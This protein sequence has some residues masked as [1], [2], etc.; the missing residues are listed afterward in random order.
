[1]TVDDFELLSAC[2]EG[3]TRQLEMLGPLAEALGVQEDKVFYLW[4]IERQ[5]CRQRGQIGSGPWWY[6]F[7]GYGCDLRNDADGR[8]LRYD[9]GPGGRADCLSSWGVLQ[10]IMTTK[11]PWQ[12]F[13][14]LR[15][16]MAEKGP[17]YDEFSGDLFKMSVA[18]DR[19]E[20]LGCFEAAD[21][22]LAEFERRCTSRGPD[23]LNYVR[24]PDGTSDQMMVDAAVARRSVLTGRARELLDVGWTRGSS[25][26]AT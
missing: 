11:E 2:F 21:T 12:Q 5:H 16:R 24:Y 18:W 14:S 23:G 20:A 10:F 7:H 25:R 22:A 6:F 15:S 4:A 17:P 9:F 8:F 26:A 1:M 3:R 19:L 13:P